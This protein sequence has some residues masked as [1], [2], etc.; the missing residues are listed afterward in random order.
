MVQQHYRIAK[1]LLNIQLIIFYYYKSLPISIMDDEITVDVL[2]R[3]R[4]LSLYILISLSLWILVPNHALSNGVSDGVPENSSVKSYGGGWSCNPGYRENKG[5]CA[6]V[7]VPENAYPTNKTYGNGWLCKHGFR[8]ISNTCMLIMV[9]ENGY[10]DYS[11][12]R[13]KCDRGYLLLDDACVEIKVPA[14]AYLM[15]SYY[16]PGWTCER[17]YQALKGACVALNIPENAHIGFSGKV[18]DCNKP[19]IERR[20]S[21]YLPE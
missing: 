15:D 8:E 14:N 12:L 7:K 4:S 21:C 16:G 19:Y 11:G 6:A 3:A 5:G 18:W 1:R 9:P 13:V 17:G 10:I 20:G 2:H